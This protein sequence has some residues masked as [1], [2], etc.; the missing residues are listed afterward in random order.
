MSKDEPIYVVRPNLPPFEEFTKQLETI[1]QTR[2]LTN[3]GQLHQQL[4]GALEER[5]GGLKIA[6]FNNA[7]IGLM[8]ACRV[9]GLE[10]EVI[11]TPFSFIATA[12]ALLW[13]DLT[14][15]FVDVDPVSLNIDPAK[16]EEAITN[17]T[18]AIMA[19]HCYGHPCDV[20]AIEA[21]A[22]KHN[23]KVIY[24]AAHV[25]DVEVNG[26]S[27]LQ[28]GDMSVLSF[29][30]TKVFSTFEGGAIVCHSEAMKDK[31]EQFKN[32][33]IVNDELIDQTG[34]NG[35]LNEAQAAMGLAQLPHIGEYLKGRARV[36][37]MYRAELADIAGI[38]CLAETGQSKSNY[39]YFPVLVGSGYGLSRDALFD[40]FKAANIIARRYFYPLISEFPM[41]QGFP[42][43][44]NE[45]LS[46]AYQ[47]SREI[48][49]LPIYPDLSEDE[50]MRVITVIK[51]NA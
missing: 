22:Q 18:S 39:A 29:H 15:V 35:K 12:H 27:I 33:G 48:L 32:F 37:A 16:I 1:W 30:A 2:W 28:Y 31:I 49:C 10:G 4:E 42:S 17:K 51:E 50:Q 8:T 38:T 43:A 44:K 20:E 14:P 36:D 21:I 19:V 46:I 7:T 40:K 41:Y 25:F 24:D 5:F 26:K 11:T 47:A 45:S 9:L 6:L 13:N 34:L 3:G 23:L